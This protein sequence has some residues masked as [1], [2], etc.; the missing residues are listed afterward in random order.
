M[1]EK[2]TE[3]ATLSL[4]HLKLALYMSFLQ[5]RICEGIKNNWWFHNSP[6]FLKSFGLLQSFSLSN[7]QSEECNANGVKL[8]LW[9][10]GDKK[11]ESLAWSLIHYISFDS[12]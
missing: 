11:T 12:L 7:L 8:Y 10:V 4:I 9:T 5:Y 3:N 1:D 6:S 2:E